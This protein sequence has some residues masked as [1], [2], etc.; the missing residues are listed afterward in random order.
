MVVQ[1][2]ELGWESPEEGALE[3]CSDSGVTCQLGVRIMRHESS[4]RARIKT[5]RA[6]PLTNLREASASESRATLLSVGSMLSLVVSV[7]CVAPPSCEATRGG[8]L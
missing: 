4:S 3:P 6:D 2:M 1:K 5:T 7:V 8:T